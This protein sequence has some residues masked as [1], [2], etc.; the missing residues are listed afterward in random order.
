M[1]V[2][3]SVDALA[4]RTLTLILLVEYALLYEAEHPFAILDV[5]ELFECPSRLLEGFT[6]DHFTWDLPE[7]ALV[8]TTV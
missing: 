5:R 1:I 3:I 2:A 7:C 8:A 6:V 4:R